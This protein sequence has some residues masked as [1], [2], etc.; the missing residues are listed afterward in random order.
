MNYDFESDFGSDIGSDFEDDFGIE[1]T[2][3]LGSLVDDEK[4]TEMSLMI[5]IVIVSV[6]PMKK[7]DGRGELW[8]ERLWRVM[9]IGIRLVEIGA[10]IKKFQTLR[11]MA[12][13][14]KEEEY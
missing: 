7:V 5:M 6:L 12:A 2:D 8:G 4:P 13:L 3:G 14:S 10:K 1:L 11:S 9:V